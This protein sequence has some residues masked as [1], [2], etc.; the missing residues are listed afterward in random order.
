M[1]FPPLSSRQLQPVRNS[2]CLAPADS[3]ALF[4]SC[5]NFLRCIV[6]RIDP[7]S[8][9]SIAC[10]HALIVLFLDFSIALML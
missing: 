5:S 3:F 4:L 6:L 9:P 2:G 1:H 8:F 7:K 10:Q